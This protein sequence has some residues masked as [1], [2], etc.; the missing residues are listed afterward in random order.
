MNKKNREFNKKLQKEIK[1][2]IKSFFISLTK[3]DKSEKRSDIVDKIKKN[4]KYENN[5]LNKLYFILGNDTN[6]S[7]DIVVKFKE[8]WN[9]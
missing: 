9:E 8:P 3:N 2:R 5:E 6:V 1:Y 4:D 7:I